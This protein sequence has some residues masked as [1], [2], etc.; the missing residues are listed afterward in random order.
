[1]FLCDLE[2]PEVIKHRPA[3]YFIAPQGEERIGDVFNVLFS[4]GW[5]CRNNRDVF[6]YYAS[7]DTGLH[8]ATSTIE[9]LLDYVTA[10]PEDPLKSH[11]CVDSGTR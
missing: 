7:S 11:L 2:R 9:H 10:T 5:M 4:N 8:V 6:I 3:G 1:M